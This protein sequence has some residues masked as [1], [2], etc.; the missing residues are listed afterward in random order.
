MKDYYSILGVPGEASRE[1]IKRAFRRLAMEYHPDRNLGN[2]KW[3]EGKFKEINEAY[4][5]LGDESRRREYD[6]ME[7]A[8][9][10]GARYGPQY[11]GQYY[12]QEQVFRDAFANPYL[13][14]EL[15]RMFQE[16]GLRFDEK[17]VDNMF[18]RGRGFTFV[19]SGQPMAGWQSTSFPSKEYKPALLLRLASKVMKF[20]LKKMLGVE[21]LPYQG[22]GGDLY[23]EIAL[24]PKEV[25][26]GV[27]KNINYK[28]GK[29][30]KRLMVKV[31]AG[32]TERTRIR[33]RGMG[34]K[35]NPPGDLYVITRIR[36]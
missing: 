11:G 6:R 22:R 15:A 2:E 21:S 35:G 27:E 5:V 20:T 7:Q 30:K 24:S 13:F 36:N 31:P 29:E 26:G 9:F 33:L 14:Q 4:A 16:A 3:A 19:F 25:A 28:R 23:H 34:L 32:V 10:A 17:F 1:E 8:G 18:F 12:T